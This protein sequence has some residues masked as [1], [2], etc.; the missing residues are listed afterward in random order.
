[1]DTAVS[2]ED[3]LPL[4]G[5]NLRPVPEFDASELQSGVGKSAMVGNST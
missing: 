4:P 3:H 1:V 5:P 2:C